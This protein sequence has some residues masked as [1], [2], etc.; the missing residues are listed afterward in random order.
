M[1]KQMLDA[2]SDAF[3]ALDSHNREVGNYELLSSNPQP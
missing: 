3:G 1:T 2:T